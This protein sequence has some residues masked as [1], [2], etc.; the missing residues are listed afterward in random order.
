[1]VECAGP[2]SVAVLNLQD[3][4]LNGTMPSNLTSLAELTV[5]GLA[6]N[7]GLTGSLPASMPSAH[8]LWMSVQASAGPRCSLA[9]SCLPVFPADT[10][11]LRS[12]GTHRTLTW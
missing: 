8:L 11:P 9:L 5:L 3:F 1:M 10:N 6:S 7:Q 12:G 4:G 2:H